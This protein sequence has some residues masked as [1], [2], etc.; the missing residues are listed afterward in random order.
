MDLLSALPSSAATLLSYICDALVQRRK[1]IQ[2]ILILAK[3]KVALSM[4]IWTSPNH[5]S[6][7]GVCA[8]FIGRLAFLPELRTP[9]NFTPHY[10]LPTM[11]QPPTTQLPCNEDN[12]LLAISAL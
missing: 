12:I 11:A 6:F 2:T 1:E 3:S 7:L 8:H 9:L 10:L 5:L 4:D